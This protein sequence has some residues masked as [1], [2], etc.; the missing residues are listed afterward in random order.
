MQLRSPRFQLLMLTG[1]LAGAG[2]AFAAPMKRVLPPPPPR[3]WV[4]TSTRPTNWAVR[5][6][7]PGL[8]NFYM[9]TTNL[10]RGAQPT[11]R[12][13]EELEGMG[14][15][16]VLN[17]RSF[18]SDEDRLDGT[19]MKQARL[20]M[21]PWHSEDEDVI[22]FLK[23]ATDTNNL[24]LFVH[25]QRGAD[26]TGMLCAM[27]RIVVCGWNKKEALDEMIDGGF[28]Y[29]STW[30]NMVRYIQKVDVAKIRQETGIPAPENSAP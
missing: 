30:Q 8:P 3:E 25:C 14:I 11:V 17:L 4:D 15:K 21:K 29:N 28:G 9:V 18:H 6:E 20:H 19:E 16:T 13:M 22:H 2:V 1:I 24:P 12:G 5:I 26:R 23:L 10:Y 7:K 27:Y